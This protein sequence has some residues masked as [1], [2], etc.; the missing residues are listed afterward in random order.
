LVTVTVYVVVEVGLT[1]IAAVVAPVLQ[2]N[3]VP[4]DAVSVVEPP[5]QIDGLLGVMLH[6]GTGFTTTVVEQDDVH[7]FT[8]LVTVTVYVVVT[9]GLTVIVAVV[10]PVLHRKD[11]PP[12]AVS[13]LEPPGQM[14]KLPHTILQLGGVISWLTV[15]S[16][17]QLSLAFKGLVIEKR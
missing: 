13:V 1:V 17:K 5:V 16:A 6:T 7:P 8:P 3:D 2:R 9:E 14:D 4:P 10:A 12:V 15:T 11:V